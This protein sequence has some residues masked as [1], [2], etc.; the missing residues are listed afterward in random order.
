MRGG[1]Y[2][3][4]N[5]LVFH[6][7]NRIWYM[8]L[9]ARFNG[10]KRQSENAVALPSGQVGVEIVCTVNSLVLDSNLSQS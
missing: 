8:Q 3:G 1:D 4:K 5:S 9:V 2:L 7:L 10:A 6:H